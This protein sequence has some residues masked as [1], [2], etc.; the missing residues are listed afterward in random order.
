MNYFKVVLATIM[1][2]FLGSF[3]ATAMGFLPP[4]NLAETPAE[5][6]APDHISAEVDFAKCLSYTAADGVCY[7][8]GGISGDEVSQFKS[9]AKEYLLEIVFVRKADAEDNDR[10]EEYIADVQLQIK[11]AKGN[12]V[13]ET[14]TEGPFFLAN[15]PPGKYQIS[16]DY[17]GVVKHNMVTISAKKHQRIVFLWPR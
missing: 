7:I 8:S 5:A 1:I 11:D 6:S 4:E 9:H 15:L 14:V 12:V 2:L 13:V 10:I 3:H 16:A 17:A